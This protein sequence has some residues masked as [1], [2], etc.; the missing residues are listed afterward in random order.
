MANRRLR[1][2]SPDDCRKLYCQYYRNQIGGAL[3]VFRGSDPYGEGLGDILRGV[4]RFLLPV[5]KSA[6]SK[7]ITTAAQGIQKGS[8]LTQAAKSALLPTLGEAVWSVGKEALAKHR[9][10]ESADQNVQ[11]WQPGKVVDQTGKG[12]KRRTRRKATKK[13]A[14]KTTGR[15]KRKST[16]SPKSGTR[17]RKR[18]YKGKSQKA[19][20][21]RTLPTNF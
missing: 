19:K 5:A 7:F 9:G 13:P 14:K 16:K 15:R 18:V 17:K 10:M 20:R 1:S 12:R 4:F 11:V 2:E 3:P 21:R 6:A 8:P